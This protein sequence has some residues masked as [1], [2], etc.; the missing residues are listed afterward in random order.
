MSH[1]LRLIRRVALP[2]I[3]AALALPAAKAQI[4]YSGTQNLNIVAGQHIYFDLDHSG[5][6]AFAS[7]GPS[8]SGANFALNFYNSNVPQIVGQSDG[9]AYPS[10]AEDINDQAFN[11]AFGQ[12]INSSIISGTDQFLAN[13]AINNNG[14][15]NA[16]WAAGTTGYL[17]LRLTSNSGATYYYGWAEIIY[18]ADKSL[19][20][21]DFAYNTVADQSIN[22]GQTSAIPEP[23]SYAAFAGLLAGSAALYAKRRRPQPAA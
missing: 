6:G 9:S 17:A 3:P 23:S 10:V 15:N 13:A 19:T 5:G 7:T 8:L 14:F 2:A 16:R 22:A 4:V 11:V 12:S 21:V 20:L 18:G 1:T